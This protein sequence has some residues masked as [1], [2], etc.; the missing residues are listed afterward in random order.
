M[1][2]DFGPNLEPIAGFADKWE[3][4][5][6]GKSWTFHIR[7]GHEVVR[8]HSRPRPT[9]ACFSWQLGLDAIK[10]ETS[11]G[12]GYLEPD[13]EDAGSPRSTARTPRR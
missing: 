2:V 12:S 6:D 7:D 1:L 3:R 13:I 10:D 8:R 4:A 5:A 11:L 9:D